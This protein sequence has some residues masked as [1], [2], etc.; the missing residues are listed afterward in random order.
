MA[1]KY[2]K[3][4]LRRDKN[5]ADIENKYEAL[6]NVLNGLAGPD[7]TFLPEDIAVINNLRNTN[8]TNNDFAQIKGLKLTY[9]DNS[10]TEQTLMPIVRLEDRLENYKV[11]TGTPPYLVGGDGLKAKFIPSQNIS[12]NITPS[13]TGDNIFNTS[14]PVPYYG[15]FMFWD[16]GAF[17]FQNLLYPDFQDSYG[18]IQW[19]GYF[20]PVPGDQNISVNYYTTGLILIEQDPFDNNNW[21][22]LKFIY[23]SSREITVTV[24][25][26]QIGVTSLVVGEN[27]K[28]VNV[29]DKI[30]NQLQDVFVTDVIFSSGTIILDTPIDLLTGDNTLI[31]NFD[32]GQTEIQSFFRVRNSFINDKIKLRITV[33]WP[34]PAD[35]STFYGS[36]TLRFIYQ[37]SIFNIGSN[38]LLSYNFLYSN[39]ERQYETEELSIEYFINNYLSSTNTKID[40]NLSVDSNI[41]IKYNPPLLP[42]DRLQN[43]LLQ[44]FTYT[45]LGKVERPNAFADVVPGDY[46][47]RKTNYTKTYMIKEKTNNSVVFINSNNDIVQ[48]F[49]ETFDGFIVKHPGLVGIYNFKA[50]YIKPLLENGESIALVK[51]NQLLLTI[52]G[53]DDSIKGFFRITSYDFDTGLTEVETIANTGEVPTTDGIAVVYRS[54]SLEDLSKLNYCKGVLG[55]EINIIAAPGSAKLYLKDTLGL[56][57]DMYVQLTGFLTETSQIDSIGSDVN[58]DFVIIKNGTVLSQIDKDVTL[59]FSPY[60]ENRE[61]CVIPLNTAPPFAGTDT[62]LTTQ[63]NNEALTVNQITVNGIEFKNTTVASTTAR[64]VSKSLLFTS[65]NETYRF[66]IK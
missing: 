47:I 50:G 65:N 7:E 6:A 34:V 1:R 37:N 45:G 46:F 13:T 28:Y 53:S 3:L 9:L 38:D 39:F 29:G 60:Q 57:V 41:L 12:T 23:N 27:I 17:E 24:A 18:M 22:T 61:V 48:T 11:I 5:L 55:K 58:G 2:R 44:T 52:D 59:A 43:S 64:D 54:S 49:G 10:N 19:E 4:G 31:F 30:T 66:L 16:N 14:V 56:Y 40:Y 8:V 15:P 26:D 25:E 51:E 20:A 35:P 63:L 32:I 62:G 36:K 33:W 21:E 42:E